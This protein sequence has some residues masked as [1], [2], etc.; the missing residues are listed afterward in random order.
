M[1][2]QKKLSKLCLTGFILMV[3]APVLI[4]LVSGTLFDFLSSS[5]FYVILAII[6]SLPVL[7][8][9]L[10]I[11]G[12]VNVRRKGLKG[13][14]FGIAGVVLGGVYTFIA[15]IVAAVGG[16][17]MW[18]L[19]PHK[20]DKR[21][22]NYYSDSEIVAVRYFSHDAE[23]YTFEELDEDRLDEFI[24]DLNSM[25]LEAGGVMGYYGGSSCGIEME[26]ED[27]TY[28]TYDGSHL[29]LRGSRIDDDITSD[30]GNSD[31][32]AVYVI[33]CDFWEVME[34]YFPSAEENP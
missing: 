30:D 34:E 4:I 10:S 16:M 20:T 19:S 1:T 29:V 7:G 11:I 14:G 31:I 24:D 9:V 8:L 15:I 13:K 25:E 33:N 21:L 28:L 23:G 22:M 12:L 27:G 26:L 17:F 6:L 32:E 2:E 5:A 18:A 3:L